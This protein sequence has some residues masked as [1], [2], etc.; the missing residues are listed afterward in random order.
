V[1]KTITLE[2]LRKDYDAVF[3]GVGAQL[4]SKLDIPGEDMQGVIHGVD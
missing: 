4:S 3:L 2:Q 1:G